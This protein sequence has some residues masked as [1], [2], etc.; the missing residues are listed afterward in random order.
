MSAIAKEVLTTADLDQLKSRLKSTW[1]TGDYDVFAR[2]MEKDAR[3]VLPAAW[4]H[5]GNQA[6]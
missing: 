5:A 4:N 1:M 2:Y 3:G 6:A